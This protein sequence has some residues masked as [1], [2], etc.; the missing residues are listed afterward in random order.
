M[1]KG[2][3]PA[4]ACL[5]MLWPATANAHLVSTGLGPFYD[6]VLH[7]MVSPEDILATLGIALLAGLSGRHIARLS[8][9]IVP[10]T[11]FIGGIVGVKFAT[12]SDWP[13]INALSLIVLGLLIAVD[14]KLPAS[15]I[16][17]LAAA[18]GALHGYL[19][20]QALGL[21]NAGTQELLGIATSA[22]V[23]ITLGSAGAAILGAG[24]GRIVLRVL[25]SWLAALG[26]LLFGWDFRGQR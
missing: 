11:W 13:F 4:I 8:I 3:A 20:G 15:I 17:L 1:K 25:G 9:L 7:L 10:V 6:G 26:L 18:V 22:L 14:G 24:K 16:A 2:S 23:V 19:N 12:A 5:L 21:V